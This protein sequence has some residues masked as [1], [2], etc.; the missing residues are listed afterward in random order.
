MTLWLRDNWDSERFIWGHT[1]ED[2]HFRKKSGFQVYIN[3]PPSSLSPPSLSRQEVKAVLCYSWT[4]VTL[5]HPSAESGHRAVS[6]RWHSPPPRGECEMSTPQPRQCLWEIMNQ[7]KLRNTWPFVE[8]IY[9]VTSFMFFF[10]PTQATSSLLFFPQT[11]AS[12]FTSITSFL[13]Y[14]GPIGYAVITPI[15]WRKK[16]RLREVKPLAWIW[17]LVCL[18]SEPRLLITRPHC[19]P[20]N[21]P[22]LYFSLRWNWNLGVCWT[23][24][25]TVGGSLWFQSSPA[26]QRCPMGPN[27]SCFPSTCPSDS[28][29]CSESSLQSKAE[30][31]SPLEKLQGGHQKSLVLIW[32]GHHLA[33]RQVSG[34]LWTSFA[35]ILK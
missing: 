3:N 8:I 19:R 10:P 20:G 9:L 21:Y 12:F 24:E 32:L 35:R 31:C 5:T 34:S 15:V 14:S 26:P 29:F 30:S 33:L 16:L 18:M 2:M 27:Y 23:W 7:M 1:A 25:W 22:L 6:H 4:K 17:I 28:C 11:F 13:S